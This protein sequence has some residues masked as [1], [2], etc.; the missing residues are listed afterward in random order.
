MEFGFVLMVAQASSAS[1]LW[2]DFSKNAFPNKNKIIFQI[3]VSES[4]FF[5]IL[6]STFEN[7]YVENNVHAC[8][9]QKCIRI[10]I[11]VQPA[12]NSHIKAYIKNK[13]GTQRNSLQTNLSHQ[14]ATAIIQL[15]ELPLCINAAP[16]MQ[17]QN[18]EKQIR[19][20]T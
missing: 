6:E 15:D 11:I 3:S 7:S 18:I 13:Y 20:T 9:L 17:F 5:L 10:T 16:A 1:Q 14:R 19:E 12:P 8:V 2:R 4:L